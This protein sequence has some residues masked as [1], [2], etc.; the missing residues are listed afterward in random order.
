MSG[1]TWQHFF[2]FKLK[3][4]FRF[5]QFSC[6]VVQ[7]QIRKSQI[8]RDQREFGFTFCEANIHTVHGRLQI[9]HQ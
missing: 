5:E 7:Y 2:G 6:F 1:H 4:F 3:E 8:P 9:H